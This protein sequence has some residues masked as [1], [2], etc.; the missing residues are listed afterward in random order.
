MTHKNPGLLHSRPKKS[1]ASILPPDV[2][3]RPP[4]AFVRPTASCIRS[5]GFP[6]RSP[7]ISGSATA[8]FSF[9][10]IA[11]ASSTM[12]KQIKAKYQ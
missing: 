7:G 5:P 4:G 11:K 1:V 10:S 8:S 12:A 6:V 2:S 9:C 3:A